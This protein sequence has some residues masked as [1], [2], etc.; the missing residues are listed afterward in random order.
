MPFLW[1]S[2]R[3]QWPPHSKPVVF[4][5]N[6]NADHA[7]APGVVGCES[8]VIPR[9]SVPAVTSW[10][11]AGLDFGLGPKLLVTPS[12]CD[13]ENVENLEDS[14]TD[15]V[16]GLPRITSCPAKLQQLTPAPPGPESQDPLAPIAC[17]P[18]ASASIGIQMRVSEGFWCLDG[19][20]D[21]QLDP[22]SPDG[23]WSVDLSSDSVA[24]ACDSSIFPVPVA[25]NLL[26]TQCSL[27]VC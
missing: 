17:S 13:S 11:Q 22:S 27:F 12:K 25:E 24:A 26:P 14:V 7:D 19:P 10:D 15:L 4:Q 16:A 3:I 18:S 20:I 8:G 23:L 21:V 5:T 6:K 2:A 1:G 9:V